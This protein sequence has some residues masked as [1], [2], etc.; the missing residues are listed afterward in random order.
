M[1]SQDDAKVQATKTLFDMG[2][3]PIVGS[4]T[5]YG[6]LVDK[7]PCYTLF[8][9]GE[10]KA[11]LNKEAYDEYPI[12]YHYPKYPINVNPFRLQMTSL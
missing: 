11:M 7:T 9:T 1:W 2:K 8:D 3:F 10:S 4:E 12:L 6:Y 5:T